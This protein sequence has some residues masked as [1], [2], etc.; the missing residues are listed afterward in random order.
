M[1]YCHE[2]THVFITFLSMEL[3][4]EAAPLKRCGTPGSMKTTRDEPADAGFYLEMEMFGGNF[5]RAR[6]MSSW[7]PKFMVRLIPSS[8]SPLKLRH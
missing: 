7:D 4:P 2:I 8:G 3:I 6:D 1:T 5:V